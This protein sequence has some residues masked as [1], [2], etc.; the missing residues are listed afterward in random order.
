MLWRILLYILLIF[1]FQFLE[2]LIPII[3][4]YENI[5]DAL[6]HIFDEIKWHR[7]LATYILLSVFLTIYVIATELVDALGKKESITMF[8]T[9]NK[10]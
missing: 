6:K 10:N 5:V 2:E 3:S 7:F 8:F 1:I 9:S 4:K